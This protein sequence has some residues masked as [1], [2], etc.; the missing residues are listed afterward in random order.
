[1]AP[2]GVIEN[3]RLTDVES[4][5]PSPRVCMSVHTEGDTPSSARLHERSH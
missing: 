1:M 5:L 3:M 4:P 2:V